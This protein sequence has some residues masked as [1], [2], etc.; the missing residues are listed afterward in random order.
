MSKAI[1]VRNSGPS[2]QSSFSLN[3]DGDNVQIELIE[4]GERKG[5]VIF[6]GKNFSPQ[7]YQERG[8]KKDE[9]RF[10]SASPKKK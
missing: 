1:I 9:K 10:F 5:E 4:W 3:A 7:A 6:T 2:T 8:G